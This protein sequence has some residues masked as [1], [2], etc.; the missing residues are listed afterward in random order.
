MMECVIKSS[1]AHILRSGWKNE[2]L[3]ILLLDFHRNVDWLRI[4]IDIL[5]FFLTSQWCCSANVEQSVKLH[6]IV[7]P[8]LYWYQIKI[9]TPVINR[10]YFTYRNALINLMIMLLCTFLKYQ[11]QL[12]LPR[13]QNFD[14]Q[15]FLG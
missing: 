2:W 3:R 8:V 6:V 7:M 12:Y 4:D 10:F 14:F 13:F 9:K 1:V 5:Y 11:L 15:D